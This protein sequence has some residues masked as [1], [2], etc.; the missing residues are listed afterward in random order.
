MAMDPTNLSENR[1]RPCLLLKDREVTVCL[2]QLGAKY[3]RLGG[4]KKCSAIHAKDFGKKSV[5]KSL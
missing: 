1:I 2:G 5:P 3:L 4:Q